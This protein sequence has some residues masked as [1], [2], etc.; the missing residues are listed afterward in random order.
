M[1]KGYYYM[2]ALPSSDMPGHLRLHQR[3]Y[4]GL[5]RCQEHQSIDF[6][7]S[8]DWDTLKWHIARTSMAMANL[9]DGGI[10]VVGVSERGESWELTGISSEH[11]STYDFDNIS[12][13]IAKYSSIPLELDV[14]V[15]RYR[16]SK[17]YLAIQISEFLHLPCICKRNSSNDAKAF[18]KG[19]ILI[20]PPGKPQTKKAEDADE[21]RDLVELAAEKRA[22]Q[23]IEAA[24]RIGLAGSPGPSIDEFLDKELED[25]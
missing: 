9:R 1:P 17:N 3:V 2:S 5:D 20:R 21:I 18:I 25:L 16:D 24:G 12:D 10:I 22:R 15:V 14:V 4:D 19:D 13:F 6:K 11:L 7:E 8:A 23:I